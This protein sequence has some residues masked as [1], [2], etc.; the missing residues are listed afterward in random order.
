[1]EVRKWNC[2]CIVVIY[3]PDKESILGFCDRV[4]I[5]DKFIILENSKSIPVKLNFRGI[6]IHYKDFYSNSEPIPDS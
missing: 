1:M 4:L 3:V 2:S 5:A 6:F